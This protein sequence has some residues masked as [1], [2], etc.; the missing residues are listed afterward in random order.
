MPIFV[1][2]GS[3]LRKLQV[4]APDRLLRPADFGYPRMRR[5][6]VAYPARGL[7]NQRNEEPK[8]KA[9]KRKPQ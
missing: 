1:F 9:V 8:L 4:H 5:G 7:V 6:A 3:V 2:S